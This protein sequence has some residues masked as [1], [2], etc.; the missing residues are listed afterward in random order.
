MKICPVCNDTFPDELNFCD[1]DGTRLGREASETQGKDRG[2]WWSLL[3]AGLLVGAVVIS[4]ASIIFLP[5]ARVALPAV[6]SEPQPLPAPKAASADGTAPENSAT[7]AAANPASEPDASAADS[8]APESRKKEKAAANS[9]N[10]EAPN[11]KAA[12]LAAE[13]VDTTASPRDANKNATSAATKPEPPPA[14]KPVTD[15]HPAETAT[16]PAQA[17]EVKRDHQT[18]AVNSKSSDK[19]SDKKK[20]DD[21][22]KKKGGF[23]RVFK[24]IFGKD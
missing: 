13:G 6:N 16:K 5:K 3:G 24:K 23:L 12:A 1:V 11:P 17:A 2:N 4:A 19:S 10:G 8:A 9:N 15:T 7:V 20:N 21:K 22:D 14:L 18:T